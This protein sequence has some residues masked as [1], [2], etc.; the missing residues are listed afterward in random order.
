[1]Q[2]SWSQLYDLVHSMSGSEKGHFKKSVSGYS[3][4]E[5]GY[6]MLFN[7]LAGMKV[8]EEKLFEKKMYGKVKSIYSTRRFL[9][10]QLIR[11]LRVYHAEDSIA[12][13]LRQLLDEVAILKERKLNEFSNELISK[14]LKLAEKH[15]QYSYKMMLLVEKRQMLKFENEQVRKQQTEIVTGEIIATAGVIVQIEMIKKSHEQTLEWINRNIPLR[16]DLIRKKAENLLTSLLE[17]DLSAFTNF[18]S[19]NFLFASISNIYFL[20]NDLDNAILYQQRSVKLLETIDL[21]KI[22][23]QMGYASAVYNLCNLYVNNKNEKGVAI[24]IKKLRDIQTLDEAEIEYI[25]N[26]IHYAEIAEM[27]AGK[28]VSKKELHKIQEF[29]KLPKVIPALFSDAQFTLL[30]YNIYINDWGNALQ[31][32]NFLLSNEN[33]HAQISIHIHSRL[34]QILVHYKLGN[35]LLLPSLIRHTYRFMLKHELSYKIEGY[36][37]QF[38]QKVLSS[39]SNKELINLLEDLLQKIRNTSSDVQE[40]RVLDYYFNYEVFLEKELGGIKKIV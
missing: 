29:L 23:R 17:I 24:C 19:L 16:D 25:D 26:L 38:F 14:G 37:L 33:T 36:L 28:N 9:Y 3:Q 39:V 8:F 1:M 30:S 13:Q 34:L 31:H 35:M 5:H 7:I 21:K 27:K 20:F 18:N 10:E 40:R 22:K 6:V 12:F 2:I 15:D 11:S 32:I 4:K